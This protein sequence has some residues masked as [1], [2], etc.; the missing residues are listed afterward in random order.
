MTI[1]ELAQFFK[2]T[3]DANMIY[4][5]QI[6]ADNVETSKLISGAQKDGD[7]LLH[8]ITVKAQNITEDDSKLGDLEVHAIAIKDENTIS[9]LC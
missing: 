6:I 2:Y 8:G 9:I 5:I 4:H 7:I 1:R 3:E